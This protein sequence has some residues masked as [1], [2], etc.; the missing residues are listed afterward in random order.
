MEFSG[1]YI[2]TAAGV[3]LLAMIAWYTMVVAMFAFFGGFVFFL[4]SQGRVVP[5]HRVS[6]VIHAI[7]CGVAGLSYFLIQDNYRHFLQSLDHQN[8]AAGAAGNNNL[9][10]AGYVAIGQYRYFDWSI[11][12]PLLLLGSVLILRLR[13]RDVLWPVVGLMVA[14]LFMIFTGYIGDNKITAT[15]NILSGQRQFWGIISTIGYIFIPILLFTAFRKYQKTAHA[16]ENRAFMTM[17][18][19]TITTW[20][21]YPIGYALL[22]YAPNYNP[23]WNQIFFSIFDV[24]NKVGVGVVAYWAAAS[25]VERLNPSRDN[26]AARD[27]RQR[28]A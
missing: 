1:I 20:G 11:T 15:G 23:N 16:E 4:S 27:E 8:L 24:I 28:A 12:T 10:N 9:I 6:M 13:V 22:V 18:Y 21:V 17:A 26:P 2:P 14:D 7:I 5:E 19:A 3:G 25:V